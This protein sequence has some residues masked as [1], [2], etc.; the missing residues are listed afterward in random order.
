[1]KHLHASDL[2]E[3]C[4]KLARYKKENKDYLDYLLFSASDRDRYLNDIKSDMELQFGSID[5][6]QNLYYIKKS[7]RKIQ[8]S[9][10]RFSKYF[11][12]KAFTVELHL[13]YCK[14]LKNSNIPFRKSQQL[15]QLYER[16]L[17]RIL[18][19]VSS[20]HE[21]LRADYAGLLEELQIKDD[22]DQAWLEK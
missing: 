13:H 8:R 2:I 21:D 6:A 12:D 10:N 4:I 19:L 18:S 7:L 20:L 16:E 9:L 1:M 14:C 11:N 5:P 3:L 22:N 17:I 15:V